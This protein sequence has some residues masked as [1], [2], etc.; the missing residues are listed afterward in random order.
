[1]KLIQS[2]ETLSL[3][4][5]KAGMDEKTARRYRDTG[6]LPSQT[7]IQHTWR[8]RPD[9][10]AEVWDDLKDLLE[11]NPGLESKTLFDHLQRHDRGRFQDGQLRTLQR[12]VKT[13]RALHGPAREVFFPQT[14]RPGVLGQSDFTDMR[15]LAITIQGQAFDHLVF[16]FVLTYSNWEAATICFSE[17]FESLSEGLQDALWE[18]GRVPEV[19]QT[20]CLSAAVHKLAHPEDF[21]DRYG[22]LLR[23]YHLKGRRSNPNSPHENGDVEQR[24]HRFRKA[25]D[26]SLML[27]G[28]RDF[29]T[30]AAYADYLRK[31]LQQL[32]AGRQARLAEELAVMR[33]LPE[34]RTEVCKRISVR[35]SRFSTIRVRDNSYS[36]HSRL[37]GETVQVGLHAEHLDVYYA[38]RRLERIP[39]LRGK[40]GHAIQ[41]RHIIDW[42]VRKPGA[43]VQYRFRDDLFPTTRFRIAYDALC[44]RCTQLEASRQYVQIL[45]LA[46]YESEARVDG[47]LD[48]LLHLD[49]PISAERVEAQVHADDTAASHVPPVSVPAVD[50]TLYDGLLPSYQAEEVAA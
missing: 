44:A 40:G 8:T 18:L 10:F 4:A 33:E 27:R 24:H 34:Q 26:Q 37:I 11:L 13:W 20:D 3:A 6:K 15:S 19:Q 42:L 9:P 49:V 7:K 32:N 36:V 5:A 39:R 21:T 16:H 41:Y 1:M 12:R 29:D 17:S 28:H 2:E 14:H 25:V 43:F 46:A 31:I 30:R 50:L 22:A 45:C 47:V 48:Q 38:Q 35:V 23:H